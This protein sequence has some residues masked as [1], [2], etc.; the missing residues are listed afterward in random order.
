MT[1]LRKSIEISQKMSPHDTFAK[2]MNAGLQKGKHGLG[3]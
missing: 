2:R 1:S 3:R